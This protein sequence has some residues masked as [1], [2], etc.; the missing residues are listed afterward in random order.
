MARIMANFA[1]VAWDS[2]SVRVTFSSPKALVG[3]MQ[4]TAIPFTLT[5]VGS[6]S[7]NSMDP[8]PF[9]E[10]MSK[11]S[12]VVP[13][14]TSQDIQLDL[15]WSF[16]TPVV[17]TSY[18][19]HDPGL[20]DII[21]GDYV[22]RLRSLMPTSVVDLADPACDVI[23]IVKYNGVKLYGP[24]DIPME[25]QSGVV[26]AALSTA[27][28]SAAAKV[29]P[30]AI[31]Y[32]ADSF[33]EYTGMCSSQQASD[34][35]AA[36]SKMAS[37]YIT[38]QAVL[39][40]PYGDFPSSS[41][42]TG[43]RFNHQQDRIFDVDGDK[44][45]FLE[46]LSRPQYVA[47]IPDSQNVY[48]YS[49]DIMNFQTG[50]T[51]VVPSWFSYLGQMARYWTGSI[52]L[53]FVICGHPMIEVDFRVAMGYGPSDLATMAGPSL[54]SSNAP[55][56]VYK[57]Y[58]TVFS[59]SRVIKVTLPHLG[60]RECTPVQ[61]NYY[62]RTAYNTD[63]AT[64]FL[65]V[66]L[67]TRSSAIGPLINIPYVVYAAAGPDFQFL[68][69]RPP[70]SY[71]V[72]QCSLH[73]KE[74][75]GIVALPDSFSPRITH[76]QPL[77]YLED[78]ASLWTRFRGFI[79]PDL[80]YPACSLANT[81]AAG[82]SMSYTD[83]LTH[84]SRFFLCYSGDLSFKIVTDRDTPLNV[85]ISYADPVA[86]RNIVGENGNEAIPA[87]C[88]PAKGSVVTQTGLQPMLEFHASYRGCNTLSFVSI[89]LDNLAV[90]LTNNLNA[91]LDTNIVFA[92][93]DAD[94]VYRKAGSNFKLH[95]ET[96]V[97]DERYWL[98][99]STNLN[100]N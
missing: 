10:A 44:H 95:Y 47:S 59:G 93:A 78:V 16:R 46:Y 50:N 31:S 45:S 12:V 2:I 21:P 100:Y 34:A 83:I 32:A 25:A 84:I 77:V 24:M 94:I 14:G 5:E 76:L 52:D 17:A 58:N 53:Y 22:L 41:T 49:N 43:I 35:A 89:A 28:L 90:N 38:P 60:W 66:C 96:C 19:S 65:D 20:L 55:F 37:D 56:S 67:L 85:A 11:H 74:N 48:R 6:S 1:Y 68:D 80:A 70:V 92:G 36:L 26:G 86:G 64:T 18:L 27:A 4:V 88:D 91:P 9:V 99:T 42:S 61:F 98:P 29:A 23:V 81:S 54:V 33:C 62:N 63:Y 69:P 79:V 8:T 72:P 87:F 97:P 71:L 3:A 73:P 40:S 57:S 51:D 75:V 30:Q 39:P 15:P 82:S 7:V 13:F